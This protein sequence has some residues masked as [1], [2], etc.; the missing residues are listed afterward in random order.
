MF[1]KP[2]KNT[3]RIVICGEVN[4]GKST[5]LNALMRQRLLP[6]NLG[7]TI[8][9]AVSVRWQREAGITAWFPDGICRTIAPGDLDALRGAEYIVINSNMQ[10]LRPFELVELPMTTA[11][12]LTKDDFANVQSA[13]GLLWVTI[14]SQ[15]WRLTERRILDEL[16]HVRPA[17]GLLAIS[18][19]D[20]LRRES[21]LAKLK[22]RV[23]TETLD[24]F[25]SAHFCR[26]SPDLLEQ[27][28]HSREAWEQTGAP[29]MLTEM[30]RIAAEKRDIIGKAT[31]K[32]RHGKAMIA[33]ME[34]H[35]ISTIEAQTH[36]NVSIRS[37]M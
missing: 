30:E 12:D 23:A 3:T 26:G 20:K 32:N 10:H 22:Q 31:P 4:A 7:A 29:G 18:R 37:T 28:I 11:D 17:H 2:L 25:D 6:D 1:F 27:S 33:R 5:V 34:N 16:A 19:A 14:A 15:A 9:P 36:P 13:A 35:E 21:D 24:Y 8:R